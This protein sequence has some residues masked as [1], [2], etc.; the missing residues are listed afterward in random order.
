MLYHDALVVPLVA[1]TV[2]PGEVAADTTPH[3]STYDNAEKGA[4]AHNSCTIK[5]RVEDDVMDDVSL[6]HGVVMIS[7]GH[8]SRLTR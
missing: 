6:R 8:E 1:G 2:L 3:D 5:P 7:R 4:V